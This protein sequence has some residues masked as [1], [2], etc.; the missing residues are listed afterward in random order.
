MMLRLLLTQLILMSAVSQP[1]PFG[2]VDPATTTGTLVIYFSSDNDLDGPLPELIPATV[3]SWDKNNFMSELGI[4][5]DLIDLE[6][7]MLNL[8]TGSFAGEHWQFDG[9]QLVLHKA[10]G[11]AR[12]EMLEI[13]H[14]RTPDEVTLHKILGLGMDF[15]D[16]MTLHLDGTSLY[17]LFRRQ[18]PIIGK[19]AWNP[20]ARKLEYSYQL[21][22]LE[23]TY[24][25]QVELEPFCEGGWIAKRIRTKAVLRGNETM[26]ESFRVLAHYCE[27]RR[28]S[29][30]PLDRFPDYPVL[31]AH[32]G[33][34]FSTSDGE[35]REIP[36]EVPLK[37]EI[38]KVPSR[39]RHIM[40]GLLI[41]VGILTFLVKMGK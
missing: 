30:S 13:R 3:F 33:R 21:Q 22:G 19:M 5:R 15:A 20:E 40:L 31:E 17:G 9:D 41:V 23:A 36:R 4:L 28:G 32:D 8:A 34:V 26:T 39:L 25:H 37:R 6:F 14:G 16:S 38:E 27:V 10:P 1:M 12:A 2:T 35:L 7:Q 29:L 24:S 18:M 11:P